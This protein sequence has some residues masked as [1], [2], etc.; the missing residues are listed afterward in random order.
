MRIA[1]YQKQIVK[2]VATFRGSMLSRS[3]CKVL[4][5]LYVS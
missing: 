1:F 2:L 4:S 5:M 3:L